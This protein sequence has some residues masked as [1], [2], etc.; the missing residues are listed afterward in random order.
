M[1]DDGKWETRTAD[2]LRLRVRRMSRQDGKALQAFNETLSGETR[3]KFLPHRYDDATV[4]RV[5]QRSESGEDL[6]FGA[7]DGKRLVGYFF[8]WRV[9]ERVP[10]LGIGMLDA[11]Q[12]QGLGRQMMTILIAEARARGK[13]GIELTTTMENHAAFALYQKMG[14]RYYRDVENVDG[15]GRVV[16]ER[17]MFYEIA[18]GAKPM[19][20]KH[21]PPV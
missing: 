4:E 8:L 11:F 15:D 9:R 13:D 10:L 19:E 3:R 6:T 5:L 12:R 2:G 18:P 14:F 7:F 20:G 16:V 21:A 1:D 17:A